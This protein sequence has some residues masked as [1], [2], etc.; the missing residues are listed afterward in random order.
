MGDSS[1]DICWHVLIVLAAKLPTLPGAYPEHAPTL[2]IIQVITIS[3]KIYNLTLSD[4]E[5][6]YRLL[7]ETASAGRLQVEVGR[8]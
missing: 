3:S 2:D 7:S 4:S 1:A 6:A 8:D 5:W